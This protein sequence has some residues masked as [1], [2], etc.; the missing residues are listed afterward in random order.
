MLFSEFA[1]ILYKRCGGSAAP[2]E[3]FL[4]LFEKIMREPKTDQEKKQAAADKYNPFASL[5]PDT[6]DRLFSGKNPLNPQKVRAVLTL[7]YT[8]NFAEYIKNQSG[9]AQLAIEADFK[10]RLSDFNSDDNLGY[11]CADLFVQI[12]SDIVDGNETSSPVISSISPIPPQSNKPVTLPATSVY[13]DET[14]GKIHIG[15]IGISIPK[16]LAPPKNIAPEEEVYVREL[17]A[18][19]ADEKKTGILTV[20]DLDSLP[21]KYKINFRGQRINYYSA[22]RIDRFV[23]DAIEGGNEEADNWKSGTL[24]YI[25]DTV[26]DDYDNGYKRLVA[27]MKKVV[28]SSTT[29]VVSSFVRLVDAKEKKGVCHLLINDGEIKWVY[30]DDEDY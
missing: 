10:Q 16:E 9:D 30:N 27:V 1:N 14:D 20:A 28:D 8:H 23:R 4:L 13:Y 12:L 11:A 25:I 17:L 3:Y 15:S 18:A 7:S 5:K 29:S 24:D 22:V 26:L 6:L 19:Y 21:E 2:H